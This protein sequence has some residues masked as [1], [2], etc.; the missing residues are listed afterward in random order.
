MSNA[1]PRSCYTA[2]NNKINNKQS[3]PLINSAYMH[4]DSFVFPFFFYFI[5]I[6][7]LITTY[8]GITSKRDP[9]TLYAFGFCKRRWR[10]I[11]SNAFPRSCDTAEAVTLLSKASPIF[12]K[13]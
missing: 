8:T 3:V 1:F 5:L 2:E 4:R 12:S 9:K 10:Q 6:C 13:V 11:V 7:F